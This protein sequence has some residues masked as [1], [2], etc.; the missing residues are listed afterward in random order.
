MGVDA[1]S[2]ADAVASF[3]GTGRRFEL[4]GEVRGIRVIDDYG[5]HPTEVAAVLAAARAD[6]AGRLVVLFQPAL[7]SRTQALGDR[8]WTRVVH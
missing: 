4:R 8:I 5:H 1:A 6:G 2:A 3:G 7:F